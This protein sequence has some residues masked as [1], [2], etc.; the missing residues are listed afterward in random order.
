MSKFVPGLRLPSGKPVK[1]STWRRSVVPVLLAGLL[2]D[3]LSEGASDGPRGGQ[4]PCQEEEREEGPPPVSA[5]FASRESPPTEW[6]LEDLG[7][8]LGRVREACGQ[9]CETRE[10]G[11]E[12]GARATPGVWAEQLEKDVNCTALFAEGDIDGKSM[13]VRP[14]RR[15]S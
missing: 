2:I 11:R 6:L 15:V 7:T 9:I 8:K 3:T 10:G 12:D 1:C 4:K 5:Y 13:F 14:P